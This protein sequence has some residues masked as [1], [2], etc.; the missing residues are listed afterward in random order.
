MGLFLL[1][2]GISWKSFSV[3]RLISLSVLFLANPATRNFEALSIYLTF[4][5]IFLIERSLAF[6]LSRS[7][8]LSLVIVIKISLLTIEKS[9]KPLFC[10]RFQT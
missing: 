6:P 7:P 5:A 9:L 3:N 1:S 2:G 10:R 8:I 4:P